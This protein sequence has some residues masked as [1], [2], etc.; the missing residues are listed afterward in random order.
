MQKVL[1]VD[2]C[3]IYI[4]QYV[5]QFGSLKIDMLVLCIFPKYFSVWVSKNCDCRSV[6]ICS[7]FVGI[8]VKCS[9]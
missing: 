5:F 8:K 4:F 6:S 3:F 9:P 7:M 2:V 1:L